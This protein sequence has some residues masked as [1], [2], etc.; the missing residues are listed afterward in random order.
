MEIKEYFMG[1]PFKQY[2]HF[3]CLLFLV[4]INTSCG[5]TQ[6]SIIEDS[7]KRPKPNIIF[8]LA[9]DLGYGDVG[10]N[11]QDKIKTPHIDRMASEGLIFKQH[12]AGSPV[13]APSRA[14]LLTGFHT[15]Y[16]TVRENP[17]WT[18]SGTPVDLKDED[19]TVAEELKR[20]GYVTGMIGKWG[21]DETSTTGNPTDQGFDYFFGFKTHM[22]AHHYYPEYIWRNKEKVVLE[23]NDPDKKLGQYSHDLFAR[24]SLD[25]I[26]KNKDTTFYLHLAFTVPH[27]ELTVPEDSKQPYIG[28]GWPERPMKSG[29]YKHDPEGNTTYA[30]MVSRMDADVGRIFALLKELNLDD[31]TLVIFTSD[32]G[33]GFDNGFFN[34]NGPF[35]GKKLQLYEGGLR[36]PF[37][38]RWP[39]EIKAGTES[40]HASAFWDFLPTACD[41]AGIEP[42]AQ[43]NGISYFPTLLGNKEK[44][45]S[46][47]YFYWEVNENSGPTQAIL[48]DKW[49]GISFYE[50]QFELYDI[51]NDLGESTNLA[52]QHPEIVSKIKNLMLEV[53]TDH[54]EF[55][56]TK[57]K[58]NYN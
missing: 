52:D 44:Q 36:V 45:K 49:K 43:T 39:G 1:L 6:Q 32:H 53:R 17:A 20:A 31:N 50:K 21:L 5:N 2:L 58:P 8:I 51:E 4:T 23:G 22:E 29:H 56:L 35:K 16:A 14:V 19:V 40:G 15:G 57:R 9:D 41:I 42:S 48:T 3:F 27:N 25:F 30:G 28:K 12:Y 34:S 26:R 13:C 55:P 10:F 47:D 18:K 7:A 54:P 38:A 24:E 46:H 11:G 33:P 37:V